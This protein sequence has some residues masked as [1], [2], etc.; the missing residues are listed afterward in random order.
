MTTHGRSADF[1]DLRQEYDD[2]TIGQLIWTLTVEL[3][4]RVANRYR[5]SKFNGGAPWDD[6]S[7]E[8]L[9]QQTAVN[10]LIGEGQ[11]DYIFTV[12]DNIEDVR[13]LLTRNLKRALWRRRST[14]V[15]DRLMR[16]VRQMSVQPGFNVELAAGHRWITL[17]DK[18]SAPRSLNDAEIRIAAA[19]A[20][21][22]PRLLEREHAERASMVYSPGALREL[23]VAVI[24]QTGGVFESDLSRIF[25]IL[26]TAW[27]PASLVVD[28]DDGP[29]DVGTGALRPENEV[30]RQEMEATV[31]SFVESMD[32]TDLTVFVGKAQGWSDNAIAARSGRSRPWVANRKK[33]IRDRLELAFGESVAEPLRDEAAALLIEQ[34]SRALGET[35]E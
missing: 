2:Q 30:E 16:R 34:A 25:R 7:I 22:V 24:E 21:P 15:V 11:I 5:P 14:T 19:A 1:A 28:E 9:A 12:A 29:A 31:R 13:R 18:P 33:A 27:L 35:L 23:L 20:H 26:L 6:A 4:G 32:S 8:E 3:A 17:T 10:L